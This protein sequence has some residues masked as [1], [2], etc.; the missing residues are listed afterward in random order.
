LN[1]YDTS[2]KELVLNIESIFQSISN[3]LETQKGTRLFNPEFGSELEDIIFDPMDELSA[4]QVENMLIDAIGRW[5]P[6]ITVDLSRTN[7]VFL[8]DDNIFEVTIAFK[9]RGY[10]GQKFEYRAS[11][12]AGN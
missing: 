10:T 1:Q 3:I 7:V 12:F 6:R 5:E 4:I 9:I 11:I 2:S 8:E